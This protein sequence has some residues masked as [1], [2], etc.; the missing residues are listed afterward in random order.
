[1]T[2]VSWPSTLS[3]KFFP[4]K[5]FTKFHIPFTVQDTIPCKFSFQAT[6]LLANK[7]FEIDI[8]PSTRQKIETVFVKSQIGQNVL[9]L[10]NVNQT[11]VCQQNYTILSNP[12]Q[13]D[14]IEFNFHKSDC[15]SILSWVF[16]W[17]YFLAWSI[18]FYPQVFLNHKRKSTN[19]LSPD[20]CALNVLGFF[21]YMVYNF[22]LYS[23][24]GLLQEFMSRNQF[25]RERDAKIY[26]QSSDL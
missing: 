12:Y 17:T 25:S 19:G 14:F 24:S 15:L 2:I 26:F 9:R 10:E 4:D 13:N 23:E 3:S 11:V 7:T 20:F 16:G 18:S 6:D 8:P 22:S 21:A 5:N 1:M